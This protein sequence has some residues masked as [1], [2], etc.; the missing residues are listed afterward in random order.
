MENYE[1]ELYWALTV[2]TDMRVAHNR[3]H[4]ILVENNNNNMVGWM[5]LA[6]KYLVPK[7]NYTLTF[8]LS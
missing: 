5:S 8:G 1:V 4:I 3:P 2:Q 7:N 6:A